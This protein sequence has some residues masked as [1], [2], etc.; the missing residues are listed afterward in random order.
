MMAA[1]RKP[2]DKVAAAPRGQGRLS[3]SELTAPQREAEGIIV[4]G[5]TA[6][7]AAAKL[8]AWMKENKLIAG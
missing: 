8:V 6:Q 7:D 2:V 5:E 4:Q 3:W 1:K